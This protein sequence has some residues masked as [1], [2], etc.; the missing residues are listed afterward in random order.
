MPP[1]R[2]GGVP[3]RGNPMIKRHSPQKKILLGF[4]GAR[5]RV[6]G[7][8]FRTNPR[9]AS[10]ARARVCW[11]EPKKRR[12][13]PARLV[14]VCR[15]GAALMTRVPPPLGGVLMVRI[16]GEDPTPWVEGI[17]LGADRNEKG[18]YRVRVKFRDLCPNF[19]LK[20]AVLDTIDPSDLPPPE[21]EDQDGPYAS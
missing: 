9:H 3:I 18:L 17:V 1:G 8:S 15:A 19:F 6:A 14:N 5:P 16:V 13:V 21:S 10:R 20:A 2:G 12:E 7:E 11:T 4:L